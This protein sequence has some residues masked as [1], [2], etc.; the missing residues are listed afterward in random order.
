MRDLC[1][2]AGG[3]RSARS[4]DALEDGPI[5]DALLPLMRINGKL[6]VLPNALHF[7]CPAASE[8]PAKKQTDRQRHA[9]EDAIRE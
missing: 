7:Y 8:R 1:G 4:A 6:Y 2:C 5:G 9:G 3:K